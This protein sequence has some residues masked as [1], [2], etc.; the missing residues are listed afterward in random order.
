[1][2]VANGGGGGGGAAKT[3]TSTSIAGG[4]GDDGQLG[5][6]VAKGGDAGGGGAGGGGDGGALGKT[7]K[8][9]V[10]GASAGG[11]GGAAGRIRLNARGDRLPTVAGQAVV[12]PAPTT[13]TIARHH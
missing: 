13:G 2:L 3:G 1:T 4:P 6:D 12:S 5:T 10:G 11:G 9:G 7:P 8:D